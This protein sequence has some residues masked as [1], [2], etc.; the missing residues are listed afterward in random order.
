[1]V[2]HNV[3]NYEGDTRVI[4]TYLINLNLLLNRVFRD[5]KVKFMTIDIKYFYLATQLEDD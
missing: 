3:L 4:T 2:G 5:P 1:M